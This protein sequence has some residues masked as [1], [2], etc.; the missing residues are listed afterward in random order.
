MDFFSA[1]ASD[2]MDNHDDWRGRKTCSSM[3]VESL[4]LGVIYVCDLGGIILLHL[5]KHLK[6]SKDHAA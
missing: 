2:T 1:L 3:L 5:C 6:D 4:L